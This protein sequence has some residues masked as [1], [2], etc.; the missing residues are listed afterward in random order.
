MDSILSD[1]LPGNDLF[2]RR[3]RNLK[4][5]VQAVVRKG[6]L[7]QPRCWSTKRARRRTR[8]QRPPLQPRCWPTTSSADALLEDYRATSA[9]NTQTQACWPTRARTTTF[10]QP[11]KLPWRGARPQALPLTYYTIA[12]GT[13][14]WPT[15]LRYEGPANSRRLSD[16]GEAT[17]KRAF[18]CQTGRFAQQR[19]QR[20]SDHAHAGAASVAVN[21]WNIARTL[22]LDARPRALLGTAFNC[23]AH[24]QANNVYGR[25]GRP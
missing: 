10:L 23:G 7:Y 14:R 25:P 21:P 11:T 17:H 12:Q 1:R 2:L 3:I 6:G 20:G 24:V 16:N 22:Q 9:Q 15:S 8:R 19:R 13:V 5:C 4:S 18:C